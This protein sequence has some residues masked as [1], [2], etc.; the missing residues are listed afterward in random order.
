MGK[1]PHQR[2]HHHPLLLSIYGTVLIQSS[3]VTDC[4]RKK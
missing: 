1:L 4:D 2:G 3:K